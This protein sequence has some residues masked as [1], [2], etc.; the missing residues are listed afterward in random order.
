MGRL[1]CLKYFLQS[2]LE[3]SDQVS[4]KL[5]SEIDERNS[6]AAQL[7]HL[8]SLSIRPCY[9][10]NLFESTSRHSGSPFTRLNIFWNTLR[11]SPALPI[12]PSTLASRK[13]AAA[14]F[15]SAFVTVSSNLSSNV[16]SSYCQRDGLQITDA[17]QH[18]FRHVPL[19]SS[20]AF[21]A[22][23]RWTMSHD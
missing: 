11:F 21:K 2:S 20:N 9:V 13:R 1:Y 22:H 7:Y 6:R 23:H 14:A 4:A 3:W 12:L 19:R 17:P 5:V 18:L 8:F 15:W 16:A 10:N